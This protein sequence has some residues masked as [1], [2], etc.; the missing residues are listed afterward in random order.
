MFYWRSRSPR[1]DPIQDHETSYLVSFDSGD[2][3]CEKVMY[4]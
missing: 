2:E 3:S 4:R 1:G